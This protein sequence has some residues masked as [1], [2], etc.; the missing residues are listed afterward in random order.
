MRVMGINSFRA[1]PHRILPELQEKA[2][3]MP[4]WPASGSVRVIDDVVVVKLGPGAGG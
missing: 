3:D 4:A 1:V 2:A